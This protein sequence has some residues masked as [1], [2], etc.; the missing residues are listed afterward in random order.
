VSES[1]RHARL[2]ADLESLE[3]LKRDSTIFDFEAN[4]HPPD[5][6]TLIFRG[7]GMQRDPST[8]GEVE[9]I[10]LH[11]CDLRLPYSYPDRPPDIRWITSIFHPNISFSGFINLRDIG[12]SWHSG[13]TLAEVC[14]RLWDVARLSYMNLDRAVNYAARNWHK[15]QQELELPVDTRSLR[16]RV[17]P[18]NPNVVRYERRGAERA[19]RPRLLEGDVLY[20]GEDTPAPEVP[21]GGAWS[22]DDNILYIE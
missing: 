21:R 15:E 3:A 14:E 18:V 16:D 1:A 17:R 20:I 22:D 13:S 11:R 6:Y 4:G 8:R 5:R 10:E 2:Q 19:V 9:L 12:L 7:K